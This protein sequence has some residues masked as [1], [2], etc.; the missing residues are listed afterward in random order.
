MSNFYVAVNGLSTNTGTLQ[1]PWSLSY[2]FAGASGSIAPGD[3]VWI[4]SGSY[5]LGSYT[6]DYLQPNH[7]GFVSVACSGVIG[8]PITFR[9]TSSSPVQ[10]PA[11][12]G[13][14][15]ILATDFVLRDVRVAYDMDNL[16]DGQTNPSTDI[17][18]HTSGVS[19]EA[20][21][22]TLQHVL[23]HDTAG[24]GSFS[25]SVGL[26]LQDCIIYNGGW[27]TPL[28]GG[29]HAHYTQTQRTPILPQ[30][31]KRFHA[32]VCFSQFGSNGKYG[33]SDNSDTIGVEMNGCTSFDAG[34]PTRAANLY[35]YNLLTDG[36]LTRKGD[37]VLRDSS[38]WHRDNNH[39]TYSSASYNVN[40]LLGDDNSGSRPLL[41]Q[42]CKF[43]GIVN[44]GLWNNFTVEDSSFTMG[45]D[46][47]PVL[48]G[49]PM[50]RLAVPYGTGSHAGWTFRRNRYAHNGDPR[51]FLWNGGNMHS[52]A[53]WQAGTGFDSGSTFTSGTFSTPEVQFVPSEIETGKATITIW[54]QPTASVVNV[55]PSSVLNVGDR[56]T[57]HHVYD[58][59]EGLPA[60]IESTYTGGTIAVPMVTKTPPTPQ[61]WTPLPDLPPTFGVFILRLAQNMI[62]TDRPRIRKSSGGTI[63]KG[64]TSGTG[65]RFTVK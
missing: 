58:Y 48:L 15:R 56:Y 60:T 17:P 43:Q 38:F 26:Q 63:F 49:R 24:L 22:V 42:R 25:L 36:G 45:N 1:S 33:G 19:V 28:R 23:M 47:L 52:F 41:V 50:I 27:Q 11:I 16:R 39:F 5:V 65:T 61:A 14:L 44:L 51:V 35:S 3:T 46:S 12:K 6:T 30:D 59:V 21:R 7:R 29:A 57:L 62:S 13:D 8:N 2:A 4:T 64:R 55:D 9:G 54:N 53:Q 32:L 20:A 37:I 40:V 10:M 34:L 31:T 18:R